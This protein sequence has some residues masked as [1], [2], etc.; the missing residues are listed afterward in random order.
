MQLLLYLPCAVKPAR[1]KG[2]AAALHPR[3]SPATVQTQR[4]HGKILLHQLPLPVPRVHQLWA[5]AQLLQRFIAHHDDD[6]GRSGRDDAG[7]EAF[8]QPPGTFL[9]NELFEGENDGALAFHL[10]GQNKH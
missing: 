4:V 7:R 6:G 9:C 3:L 5:Q 2:T 8:S 10:Q 1:E